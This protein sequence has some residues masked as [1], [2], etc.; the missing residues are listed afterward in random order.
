MRRVAIILLAV[1]LLAPQA[2]SA[3]QDA[4]TRPTL[5]VADV[6]LV[7][8]APAD[9]RYDEVEDGA[10]AGMLTRRLR[11]AIARSAR[12]RVLDRGVDDHRP[13]YRYADCKACLM[14]W[15]R[16][17]DADYV[18]VTTLQKESRLILMVNMMLADVAHPD[19]PARGG[20]VD[21]RGD[22]DATWL[23][24]AGQLLERTLNLKMLP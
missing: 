11:A 14:E 9:Q 5:L 7:Q 22:T 2:S 13:P 8:L 6:E 24:G 23:A 15:A 4:T 1:L 20:M 10:R 3:R 12:Y 16:S 21:L 19:R 17:R 18:L